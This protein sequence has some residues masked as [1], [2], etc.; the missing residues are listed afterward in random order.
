MSHLVQLAMGKSEPSFNKTSRRIRNGG[1]CTR[2]RKS[3]RRCNGLK[4]CSTC[5]RYDY[6]CI[7]ESTS[8]PVEVVDKVQD[9]APN[10]DRTAESNL[11]METRQNGTE[12]PVLAIVRVGIELPSRSSDDESGERLREE[13]S[14]AISSSSSFQRLIG[15]LDYRN[16]S[17]FQTP[18]FNFGIPSPQYFPRGDIPEIP[19]LISIEQLFIYSSSFFESVNPVYG[20]INRDQF[21]NFVTFEYNNDRSVPISRE[22]SY[23]KPVICGVIALGCLFSRKNKVFNPEFT[24]YLEQITLSKVQDTLEHPRS[25]D[26]ISADAAG[27]FQVMAWMLRMIYLRLTATPISCWV[28]CT[29]SATIASFINLNDERKWGS[30]KQD[31]NHLRHLFWCLE[32]F[33]TWLSREIA[34]PRISFTCLR[35]QYPVATDERDM[36]PALVEIYDK[37]KSIFV[38]GGIEPELC[39]NALYS[40]MEFETSDPVV[41]LD[42]SYLAIVLFRRMKVFNV[43]ESTL[44]GLVKIA[45][46]SLSCC[47]EL[48]TKT[49]PWWQV[50]NVPFHLLSMVIVIDQPEFTSQIQDIIKTM[51]IVSQ[52]FNT[53]E[54]S[55]TIGISKE[56][57]TLLKK[58]KEKELASLS[59]GIS[60][61]ENALRK[62]DS[63]SASGDFDHN[64]LL[65]ELL[66]MNE[67]FA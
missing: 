11:T 8:R 28:A 40:L 29:R 1:A 34:L 45:M 49:H 65:N 56:L 59:G 30:L 66:M 2:C 18:A 32:I 53:Q 62:D 16:S 44:S 57:I 58:R 26:D 12:K 4:P 9:C 67:R 36:A 21:E 19:S 25:V 24:A 5:I 48:A 47:E 60:E 52:Q 42:R 61:A 20:I 13:L 17:K 7:Y 43:S 50:I 39:Y 27:V 64:L 15:M 23:Y 33:N 10:V 51:Y 46:Q 31:P 14:D 38:P 6:E 54:V 37:T 41:S 35:C 3:R 63:E 55:N 22:A